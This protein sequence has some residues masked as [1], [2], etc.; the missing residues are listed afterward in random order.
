MTWTLRAQG[1]TPPED[2]HFVGIE[3]V[4]VTSSALRRVG[5]NEIAGA[6][7][8]LA[9]AGVMRRLDHF[10]VLEREEDGVR[11]YAIDDRRAVT[12]LLPDDW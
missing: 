9:I 12:F 4:L 8:A 1:Y 11:L 2:G 7:A 6:L 3:A 5:A 10:Q